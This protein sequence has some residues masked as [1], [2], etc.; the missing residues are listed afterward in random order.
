[1][2]SSKY[3]VGSNV[4]YS[5]V[6]QKQGM[7]FSGYWRI[8][9]RGGG[10]GFSTLAKTFNSLIDKS[11]PHFRD[12]SLFLTYKLKSCSIYPSYVDGGVVIIAMPRTPMRNDRVSLLLTIPIKT[13]VISTTYD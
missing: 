13:N 10:V 12:F 8:L 3:H 2:L 1:M 4:D 5:K 9:G 11:Y 7:P 6:T